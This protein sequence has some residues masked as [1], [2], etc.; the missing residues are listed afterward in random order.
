MNTSG[1]TPVLYYHSVAENCLS[2][3][4]SVFRAQLA[5]LEQHGYGCISLGE[6]LTSQGSTQAV[7]RRVVLTFDDGFGSM[8]ENVLP[9]LKEFGFRATFFIVPGYV[10]KTLWGDPLTRRWSME[11]NHGRLPFSM[12]NWDQI[13]RMTEAHMEIGSHTLSHP[14]LT[15]ISE[16]DARTEICESKEYLE[17]KLAVQVRGFCF[18]GG[19]ANGTLAR[20][21]RESGYDY[22]CTT[23]QAHVTTDSNHFLLPRIPGPASVSDL[24]FRVNRI[25]SNLLTESALRVARYLETHRLEVRAIT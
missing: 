6:W 24:F 8:W 3:Y 18:P 13:V 20:L 12:M 2:V 4:P 25:P 15:D 23:Q 10:G 1:A 5:Y 19:R 9:L 17:E 14:D 16:E 11:E 22:A 21:V 7:E